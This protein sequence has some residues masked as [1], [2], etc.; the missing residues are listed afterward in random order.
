MKWSQNI[1][2]SIKS[3]I[4]EEANKIQEK[5]ELYYRIRED[6]YKKEKYRRSYRVNKKVLLIGLC[7]ALLAT[8]TAVA[9]R[10]SGWDIQLLKCYEQLPTHKQIKKESGFSPKFV[11][12]LPGGYNF[13]MASTHKGEL[14]DEHNHVS[15]KGNEF[16]LR[17]FAPGEEEEGHAIAFFATDITEHINEKGVIKRISIKNGDIPL[18]FADWEE[19][20]VT[21]G[22]EITKEEQKQMEEG[23][24]LIEETDDE[25]YLQQG[26]ER[27]QAISWYEDG[28]GYTLISANNHQF[29]QEEFVEMARTII[30]SEE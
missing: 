25:Y 21:K 27:T 3:A 12:T 30:A 17:Y 5:D 20:Y 28:I 10:V 7:T 2:H 11:G 4:K 18:E 29:T 15:D 13:M 26:T 16:V 6:I 14:I 8:G 23:T 9:A 24:L 19:K 1:E 22:Y